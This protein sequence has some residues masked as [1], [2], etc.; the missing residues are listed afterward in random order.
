MERDA[1]WVD[2]GFEGRR[3]CQLVIAEVDKPTTVYQGK[4]SKQ[5]S[6]TT[7]AIHIDKENL[8]LI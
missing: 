1:G 8:N 5:Q 3:A 4:Y 2:P 6:T 7:S